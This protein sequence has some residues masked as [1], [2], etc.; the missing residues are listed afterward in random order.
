VPLS[1]H[2]AD[3]L[4]EELEVGLD[5][6]ICLA[7]LSFVSMA[8]DGGDPSDIAHE[9]RRMTPD[10]WHDG[11]SEIAIAAVRC[12]RDLGVADADAALADLEERGGRSVVARAIVQTL[13][14]ELSRRVHTTAHVEK[15]ARGRSLLALPEWNCADAND[16][17]I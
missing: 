16:A 5:S 14:E 11:L 15:T 12:A 1:A 4:A 6:G 7:C 13:A 17:K 10:I 3:A 9:L 2:D 8:L